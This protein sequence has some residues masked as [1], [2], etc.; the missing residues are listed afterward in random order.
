MSNNT[1]AKTTTTFF[2]ATG[3]AVNGVL[4]GRLFRTMRYAQAWAAQFA[5]ARIFQKEVVTK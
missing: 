4:P 5:D 2:V 1:A 3:S